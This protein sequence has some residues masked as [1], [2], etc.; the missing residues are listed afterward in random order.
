MNTHVEKDD[1]IS[2]GICPSLCPEIFEFDEDGIA[3]AKTEEVPE[4]LEDLVLE[5]AESCPTEAIVLN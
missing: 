4:D 5:A 1:C 2:C 3:Y